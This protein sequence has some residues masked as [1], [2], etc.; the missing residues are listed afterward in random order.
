[1]ANEL[2]VIPKKVSKTAGQRMDGA[3][4]KTSEGLKKAASHV[5]R[6]K[7]A[8]IAGGVGALGA[9]GAYVAGRLQGK[10]AAQ[11]QD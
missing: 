5:T 3:I 11:S 2:V 10:K 8:Y 7:A 1:M 6:N 4:Q 9:G